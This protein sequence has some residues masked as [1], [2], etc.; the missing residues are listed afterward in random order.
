MKQI[1]VFLGVLLSV[2][3]TAFKAKNFNIDFGDGINLQRSGSV[4]YSPGLMISVEKGIH[5]SIGVFAYG[6]FQYNINSYWLSNYNDNYV[7]IPF[8]VTGYFHFYQMIYDLVVKEICSDKLD[9]S[10]KHSVGAR[11]D[12]QDEF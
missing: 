2:F 4:F 8:G 6:G 7:A 5:K 1:I 10:I 9:V 11:L 12:F 3:A